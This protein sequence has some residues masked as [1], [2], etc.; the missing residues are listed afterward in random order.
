MPAVA[1][2]SRAS[3]GGLS[4]ACGAITSMSPNYAFWENERP[5]VGAGGAGY[6]VVCEEDSCTTNRH[7]QSPYL[8]ADVV[9]GGDLLAAGDAERAVI[10]FVFHRAAAHASIGPRRG[11]AGRDTAS[12]AFRRMSH[13]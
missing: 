6:L 4:R 3:A 7:N 12:R 2:P 11:R 8:W 1:T 10:A 13:A 9:A 5:A